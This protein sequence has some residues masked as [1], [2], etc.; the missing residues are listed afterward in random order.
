M[1]A[2][3]R[4]AGP[5]GVLMELPRLL[6][7]LGGPKPLNRLFTSLMQEC[8]A[9]SAGSVPCLEATLGHRMMWV[10]V[11]YLACLSV[12]LECAYRAPLIEDV[13]ATERE[14]PNFKR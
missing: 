12:F 6:R 10:C 1:V 13:S 14:R 9:V 3:V 2:Q 7:S 8:G 5:V 11:A 4:G